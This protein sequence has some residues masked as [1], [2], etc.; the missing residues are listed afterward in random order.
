M[1][2]EH[3]PQCFCP[4]SIAR[5]YVSR[6]ANLGPDRSSQWFKCKVTWEAS[7]KAALI[8]AWGRDKLVEYLTAL[9][10]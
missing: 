5:E 6:G 8:H 1:L 2:P 4:P 10:K 9:L 7:G 3:L